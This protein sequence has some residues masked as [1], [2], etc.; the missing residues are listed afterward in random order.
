MLFGGSVRYDMLHKHKGYVHSSVLCPV[1]EMV[2]CLKQRNVCVP[3][4]SIASRFYCISSF[5]IDS[6]KEH[7]DVY[8]QYPLYK[9]ILY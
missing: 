5:L 1:A 8:Y 3:L 4:D 6:I 9:Q 2:I 7:E